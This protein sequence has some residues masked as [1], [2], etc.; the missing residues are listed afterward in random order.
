[1]DETIFG[2]DGTNE[3]QLHDRMSLEIGSQ[4]QPPPTASENSGSSGWDRRKF[5]NERKIASDNSQ[6]QSV[7]AR[8]YLELD[9]RFFFLV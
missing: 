4:T 8:A 6:Y 3:R 1:M 9:A 7:A 5:I 2:S